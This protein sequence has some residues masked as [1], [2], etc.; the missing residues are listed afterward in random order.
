MLNRLFSCINKPDHKSDLRCLSEQISYFMDDIRYA[1]QNRN[2]D[3]IAP[4]DIRTKLR[5][6][7][8]AQLNALFEQEGAVLTIINKMIR[9]KPITKEEHALLVS[10]KDLSCPAITEYN[11]FAEDKPQPVKSK[12]M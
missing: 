5:H 1:I 3:H 11:H 4:W 2:F 10:R 7:G 8:I 9:E 12:P 6:Y